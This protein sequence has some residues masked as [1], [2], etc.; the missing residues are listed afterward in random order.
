MNISVAIVD[1]DDY[2]RKSLIGFLKKAGESGISSTVF[3]YPSGLDF[4]DNCNR[5]T[6]DLVLMDIEMPLMTGLETAKKFRETN[7]ETCL[8]FITN[9]MQYAVNGYEVNALDFVIKPVSYNI[10]LSKLEKACSFIRKYQKVLLTIRHKSRIVRV[11]IKSLR[12]VEVVRNSVLYH[13]ENEVYEERNTLT[14]AKKNLCDHHFELCNS[15][16]LVN[17]RHVTRVTTGSV[18]AGGTE[19]S[20]SRNKKKA[21]LEALNLYI[22]DGGI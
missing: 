10:F 5:I 21:F 18:F 14:N 15:C 20:M 1:D 4:L 8:I 3:Q 12:Y 13:T 22:G 9:M 7:P 6:F 11:D 19:L 16:Y 17:L 2:V